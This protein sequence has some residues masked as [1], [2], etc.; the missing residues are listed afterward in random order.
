MAAATE[1]QPSLF[2]MWAGKLPVP[3]AFVS[4]LVVLMLPLEGLSSYGQI[5]LAVLVMAVILWVTEALAYPVSAFLIAG[6]LALLLG[7]IPNSETGQVLGTSKALGLAMKG[8]ATS[9]IVMI[10]GALVMAAAMQATELDKRIALGILSRVQPNAT[11][12]L[13]GCLLIGVVLAFLVPSPTGRTAVQVPIL[14]GVVAAL[15]LSEKSKMAAVLVIGAAQVSTLWNVGVMTAT[16]HNVV[17]LELMAEHSGYSISWS[18]WLIYAAPWSAVMTLILFFIL[19]REL[20]GFELPANRVASL[21]TELKPWTVK[22]KKM[23][24]YSGLL[25]LLWITEGRLHHIS[26]SASIL[27]MSICLMMPGMGV[28]NGWKDV[29]HRIHWGVLIMFGVSISLGLQLVSTGAAAWVADFCFSGLDLKLVSLLML[30]LLMTAFTTVMHLGFASALSLTVAILPVFLAFAD[31]LP[32]PLAQNGISLVLLQLF[33]V[34]FGMILPVNSPQN[35]VAFS[36]DTFSVRTFV[37]IGLMLTVAT[38]VTFALFSVS[39]WQWTGL[40]RG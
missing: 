39:W 6:V 2:K 33:A 19:R 16:V 26:V 36:T 34:S 35:M 29:E 32:E 24:V 30:V 27:L 28:F 20:S 7:L 14:A 5:V 10:S 40:L 23:A 12:V 31:T 37:R 17:G 9:G 1:T 38:L 18:Q 13:A 4:L 15:G 3:L 8:F 25:L 11:A 21:N 22:Q